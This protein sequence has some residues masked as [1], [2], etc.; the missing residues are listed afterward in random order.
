MYYAVCTSQN[1]RADIRR[2]GEIGGMF[3]SHEVRG[4]M[5]G[6]V[7]FT[8]TRDWLCSFTRGTG[9][10]YWAVCT[11]QNTRLCYVHSHTP[12]DLP[13]NVPNRSILTAHL[14]ILGRQLKFDFWLQKHPPQDRPKNVPNRSFLIVNLPILGRRPKSEFWFQQHPPQ[15]RPRNIPNGSILTAHLSILGRRPKF[16][17][18]F[19]KRVPP[20]S[21]PTWPKSIDSDG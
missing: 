3:H 15:D 21:A 18:W 5:E 2:Y 1:T 20:G 11:S 14:L 8:H 19:Q 4:G 16:D 10:M 12:K 17:F 7:M 13:Q 9:V 6:L